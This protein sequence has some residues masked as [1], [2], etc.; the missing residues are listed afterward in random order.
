MPVSGTPIAIGLEVYGDGKGHWL[1]GEFSDAE[2][3]NFRINFTEQE[4]GINWAG[5]WK[6]LGISLQESFPTGS[7]G[8]G[9]ITYPITWKRIYM[10]E[11][12]ENKKDSGAIFLDDFKAIYLT[13]TVDKRSGYIPKQFE[14]NQ[15]YPNPFNPETTIGYS[16]PNSGQ[17]RL[18]I[19]DISGQ[20]IDTLV[21]ENQTPGVYKVNWRAQNYASSIYFYRLLFDDQIVATRKMVVVK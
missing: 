14:L 13:T 18:E 8:D 3:E 16:L 4:A 6:T 15:N 2:N 12:D 11:P 20:K 5:S 7:S 1:R 17:V 9:V 10:A 21:D 19:Y